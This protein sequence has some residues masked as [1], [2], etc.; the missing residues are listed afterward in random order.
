VLGFLFGFNARLGRLHYSLVSIG[1]AV[2]AAILMVAI[3]VAAYGVAAPPGVMR[4]LII[5]FVA[6][7]LWSNTMLMAMRFRDIGWDPVCVVPLWIA[8]MIVDGVVAMKVPA[9]SLTASHSGTL[10]GALINLGFSLALMFWPSG[11]MPDDDNGRRSDDAPRSTRRDSA[12]PSEARLARV[13][14]GDFG[15]RGS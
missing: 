5:L 6:L 9:W 14:S 12:M 13:S 7:S 10:A 2:A 11:D 15:R 3:L 4:W 1:L 8:S